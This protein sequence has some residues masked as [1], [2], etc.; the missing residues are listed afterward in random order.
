MDHL[1]V[2]SEAEEIIDTYTE[3]FF[4][5]NFEIREMTAYSVIDGGKR[6]RPVLGA[7]TFI[8]YRP[9]KWKDIGAYLT[10][11]EWIHSYSLIHDDLPAM[12]DDE[13]RRGKPT[14]HKAYGEGAAI[15]AGDALLNGA[16][17]LMFKDI[18]KRKES[19]ANYLKAAA[20]IMERAGAGGMIGGQLKDIDG[21]Q[22]LKTKED[23]F[24][25]IRQKT[26]ALFEAAVYTGAL[27]G[28]ATEEELKS[29]EAF[30]RS[31]GKAFQILDDISDYEEDREAG[32]V[33]LGNFYSKCEL[34]K[35]LDEEIAVQKT[36]LAG[37][38]KDTNHIEEFI[39]YYLKRE[40]EN[41]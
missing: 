23:V 41:E 40:N 20:F 26:G 32:F 7:L 34:K 38:S 17:E 11:L 2:L 22:R 3:E 15:L 31:F 16:A 29:W 14:V 9:D 1:Q 12:D 36:A 30:S 39:D 25:M 27:L 21:E 28:G 6:L 18:L 5:D 19:P 24:Q 8:T 13:L 10:A 33:T 37:I 35:L 4:S